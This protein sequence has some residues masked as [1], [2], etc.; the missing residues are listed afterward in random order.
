LRIFSL[1]VGRL[2]NGGSARSF[3]AWVVDQE[4]DI[5]CIQSTTVPE[6]TFPEYALLRGYQLFVNH[7]TRGTGHTGVAIYSRTGG[8]VAARDACDH[9]ECQGR[10]LEVMLPN[11]VRI[12]STYIRSGGATLTNSMWKQHLRCIS[13]RMRELAHHPSIVAGDFNL[14]L[15]EADLFNPVSQYG[16]R[17]D[18]CS[19]FHELLVNHGWVDSFRVVKPTAQRYSRWDARQ[20]LAYPNN[21]WRI[22]YQFAS[23]PIARTLQEADIFQAATWDERFSDHAVTL[24]HYDIA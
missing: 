4:A 23:E 17:L 7:S 14:A 24:G 6:H 9:D 18:M 3:F 12:A 21:G 5:I 11:G 19:L 20:R 2:S 10:H 16:F 22:D 1:N 15:A 8:N 13:A